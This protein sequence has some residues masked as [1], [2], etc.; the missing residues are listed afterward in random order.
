[1]KSYES[2][3]DLVSD[4]QNDLE[5]RQNPISALYRVNENNEK[6]ISHFIHLADSLEDG[7]QKVKE[8][9]EDIAYMKDILN[10]LVN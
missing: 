6:R 3:F 8:Q 5:F 10:K 9:L 1:M 4:L 7:N 2:I